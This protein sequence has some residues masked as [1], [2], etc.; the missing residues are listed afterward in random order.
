M[1]P[2]KSKRII[3]IKQK[4][5]SLL[6]KE[7]GY[8]IHLIKGE[9]ELKKRIDLY[10]KFYICISESFHL[11]AY[12]N[13]V[14]SF[15]NIVFDKGEESLNI[16][17]SYLEDG[18]KI[19]TH[20]KRLLKIYSIFKKKY[21]DYL[22]KSLIHTHPLIDIILKSL[23]NKSDNSLSECPICFETIKK[24]DCIVTNCNHYFHKLCLAKNL[25]ERHTCPIC[26]ATI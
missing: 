16:L 17:K 12:N 5:Y 22:L 10:C 20:Y 18:L 8:I 7:L 19:N 15:L 2:R 23:K 25:L 11:L 14:S 3:D 21:I 24:K 4:E 9:S 26:R 1:L 6:Y 13:S